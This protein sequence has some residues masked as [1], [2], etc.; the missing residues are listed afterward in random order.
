MLRWKLMSL[1]DV[2]QLSLLMCD[3]IIDLFGEYIL[4]L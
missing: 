2:M 3:T 4:S 1:N